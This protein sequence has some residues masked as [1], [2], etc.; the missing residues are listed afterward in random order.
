MEGHRQ[1]GIGEDDTAVRSFLTERR[2]VQLTHENIGKTSE[3]GKAELEHFDVEEA[4][5]E[6]RRLGKGLIEAT[7][8]AKRHFREE[9]L[10]QLIDRYRQRPGKPVL[11]FSDSFKRYPVILI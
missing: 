2:E 4:I 6:V 9:W 8:H 11:F 1:S 5:S 7:R 10:E 3:V